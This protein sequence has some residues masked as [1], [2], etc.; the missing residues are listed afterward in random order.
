MRLHHGD[1][2]DEG[3]VVVKGGK[4]RERER[5]GQRHAAAGRRGKCVSEEK[6]IDRRREEDEMEG[7]EVRGGG[8]AVRWET[9]RQGGVRESEKDR[10]GDREGGCEGKPVCLPALPS[11]DQYTSTAANGAVRMG[12]DV[13]ARRE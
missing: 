8:R 4:E 1:R 3:N 7:K 13:N 10:E 5:E 2:G 9:R 6:K 12:G 11:A